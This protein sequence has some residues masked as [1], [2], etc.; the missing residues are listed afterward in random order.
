[1]RTWPVIAG[2]VIGC[3]LGAVCQGA[4]GLWSLALP[5][6][7]ALLAIGLESG[8]A[9]KTGERFRARLVRRDIMSGVQPTVEEAC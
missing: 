6:S 8:E 5:A 9:Q 1:M 7:L 3:A 2:F 4:I